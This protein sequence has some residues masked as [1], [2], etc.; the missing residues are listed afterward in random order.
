MRKTTAALSSGLLA[1]L[2][3]ALSVATASAATPVATPMTGGCAGTSGV[4]VVVDLTDLGG[5]V[6]IGC[7]PG[8]PAS[9]RQALQAAGFSTTDASSGMICAIDSA[10]DPCPTTFDGKYWS[11]WSGTLGAGWAAYTVGADSSDPAPGWFEGWRYDDGTQGPSVAPAAIQAATP[12]ADAAAHE[13]PPV[14]AHRSPWTRAADIGAVAV[15]LVATVLV[16]RRRRGNSAAE[17]PAPTT[18]KD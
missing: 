2:F 12:P 8:D 15:L 6:K 9:G 5:G 1:A 17:Q 10:P 11:Y 13:D 4:T 7:A 3:A 14:A 18:P 16:A